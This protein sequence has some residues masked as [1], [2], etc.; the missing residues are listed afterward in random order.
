[1]IDFIAFRGS[2]MSNQ[3]KSYIMQIIANF[4]SPLSYISNLQYIYNN[5]FHF[6]TLTPEINICDTY[7][8]KYIYDIATSP[9]QMITIEGI[10][11]TNNHTSRVLI[12]QN[13]K[14][15]FVEDTYIRV[16]INDITHHILVDAP[17]ISTSQYFIQLPPNCSYPNLIIPPI[18]Q[19]QL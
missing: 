19:G 2:V 10:I 4:A 13:N 11:H 7:Q 17:K 8:L 1:M 6:T 12:D 5:N 9:D 18:I 15:L 14:P 3:D 16:K